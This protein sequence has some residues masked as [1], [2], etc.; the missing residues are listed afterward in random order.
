MSDWRIRLTRPVTKTHHMLRSNGGSSSGSSSIFPQIS[1]QPPTQ[2]LQ[3]QVRSRPKI[4]YWVIFDH[5]LSQKDPKT[6]NLQ[7]VTHPA[8]IYRTSRGRCLTR[9]ASTRASP[10]RRRK[11]T[12]SAM[13]VQSAWAQAATAR[14]EFPHR[15]TQL[16]K[17]LILY[18]NSLSNQKYMTCHRVTCR[19]LL[20]SN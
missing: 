6:L 9:P 12:S 10:S 13:A 18:S 1:L 19:Y 3:G 14:T 4:T 11:L 8:I 17:Y 2:Q 7:F 20:I 16:S 5:F 15:G